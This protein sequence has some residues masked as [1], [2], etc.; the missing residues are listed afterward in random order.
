[1]CRSVTERRDRRRLLALLGASVA[2]HLGILVSLPDEVF[3]APSQRPLELEIISIETT[4]PTPPEPPAPV[5]PPPTPVATV[6]RRRPPTST[7]S[8]PPSPT[9]TSD[10]PAS[11]SSANDSPA[12]GLAPT[13]SGASRLLPSS[14]FALQLG[15]GGADDGV[16]RG[17]TLRNGPDEHPDP[18]ALAEYTG[19]VL[20]RRL[21]TDL[22]EQVGLAAVEVGNV[23]G[24]FKDYE[25]A[26]RRSLPTAKIDR[27][28][29]TTGDALRDLGSVLFNEGPSSDAQKKVADSPMGRSI[30]QQNV[31]MPNVED[32]RAREGAMA[33]M[34]QFENI[35]ERALK[36][37]LRTVLELTTDASGA[38]ADV[39]IIERSGDPRFDE[40][41]VHFSR[42]VARSLPDSDEKR[43]GTSMWR[44]RWQFTWEPLGV[45][46]RLLNA[47][48]LPEGNP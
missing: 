11:S 20:T 12:V 44:T 16:V 41:V 22:R 45:K 24:H 48:P 19:E 10:A 36:A 14:S 9:R 28:P 27:T 47:W 8:A 30:A 46:V 15:T 35:K 37:R 13:P 26:M 23:P 32:Q 1:M 17:R 4:L 43:L 2:L 5:T 31:M 40:S 25:S 3:A 42:K 39:S 18:R 38:L 6:V 7:E 21:N 29:A 34:A 33:S